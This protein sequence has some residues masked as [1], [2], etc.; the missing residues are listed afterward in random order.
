MRGREF[1]YDQNQSSLPGGIPPVAHPILFRTTG[2][3]ANQPLRLGLEQFRPARQQQH[4][5]AKPARDSFGSAHQQ[6]RGGSGG[7]R[8]SQPGVVLGRHPG[9]LGHEHLRP[10]RQRHHDVKPSAGVDQHG[11]SARHQP[12]SGH[13]GRP[14]LQPGAVLERHGG[15]LGQQLLRPARKWCHGAKSR[16]GVGQHRGS[17]RQQNGG[18]HRCGLCPQPRSL[19]GWHFGRLG[20]Q[21][22]R[23]TRQQQHG[24]KPRAGFGQHGGPAR[25]Q[26]GGGHRGG[27]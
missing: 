19:F 4:G 18:D 16:A 8:K 25:Q 15:R 1:F 9:R 3:R 2:T 5:D 7:G 20:Q 21:R 26:N 17:A 22:L 13:R 11:G 12:D 27:A 24:A 10:A 6:D 14:A 23:P